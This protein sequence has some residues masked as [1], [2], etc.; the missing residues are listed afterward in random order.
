M[1]R[2]ANRLLTPV[3]GEHELREGQQEEVG[4]IPTTLRTA[5]RMFP[6]AKILTE[7]QQELSIAIE[8]EGVLHNRKDHSNSTIDV[9]F[10]IDNGWVSLR[11]IMRED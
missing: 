7:A 9:I 1:Q 3:E 8:I 5:V 4:A 10:I 11:S 6:Q 2:V